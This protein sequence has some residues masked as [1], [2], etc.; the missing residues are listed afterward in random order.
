MVSYNTYFLDYFMLTV[1]FECVRGPFFS[2]SFNFA[3]VFASLGLV[4]EAF[5]LGFQHAFFGLKNFFFDFVSMGASGNGDVMAFFV[6]FNR[7]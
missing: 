3:G 6:D 1:V 4:F 7:A 2:H 5:S